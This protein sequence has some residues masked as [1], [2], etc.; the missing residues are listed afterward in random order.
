MENAIGDGALHLACVP[1]R[2]P[3]AKTG[4]EK[5]AHAAI[6]RLRLAE[7]LPR[8]HR[9]DDRELPLIGDRLVFGLL[10]SGHAATLV[11]LERAAR[12]AKEP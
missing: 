5:A 1:V 8:R 10:A 2:M 3:G 9:P 7:A 4:G 12:A 6:H 11:P